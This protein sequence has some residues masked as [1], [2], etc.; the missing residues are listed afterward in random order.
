MGYFAKS[1]RRQVKP[2]DFFHTKNG[3]SLLG[4]GTHAGCFGSRVVGW[5][6]GGNHGYKHL[7]PGP[8]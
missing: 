2:K 4:L 1:R 6:P 7:V 8:S 5:L 3:V